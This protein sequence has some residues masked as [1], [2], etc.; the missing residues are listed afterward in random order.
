M[1]YP[2]FAWFV[3]KWGFDSLGLLND[4]LKQVVVSRRDIGIRGLGGFGRI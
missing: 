4:F 1:D 2:G 3:L